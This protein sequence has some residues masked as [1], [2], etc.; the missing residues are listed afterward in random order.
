MTDCQQHS[1]SIDLFERIFC[2]YENKLPILRGRIFV[3][4]T[5]NPVDS[6]VNY[7]FK[8]GTYLAILTRHGIFWDCEL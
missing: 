2:V 1:D 6:A 5:L 4:N 7:R 3:P 8:S